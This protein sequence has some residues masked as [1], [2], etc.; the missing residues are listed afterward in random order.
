MHENVSGWMIAGVACLVLTGFGVAPVAM[1]GV[2]PQVKKPVAD[3]TGKPVPQSTIDDNS[4]EHSR[5]FEEWIAEMME[6]RPYPKSSIV[7]LDKNYARPHKASRWK[8]RIVRETADTVWLQPLPPEDPGSILH[9]FWLQEQ[10]RQALILHNL[11]HPEKVNMLNFDEPRAPLPFQDAL[12]FR[13]SQDGLPRSGQWRNNFVL[14]DLNEDGHA[15]MLM[16]PPR[17]GQFR[18]PVILLGDGHGKFRQW[19]TV[20]WPG[21]V[22]FDYGGV[23]VA[24][25]D[26]DGHQDVV[27]AIHFKDQYVLFGDGKGGFTRFQ[28]LPTPK[29]EVHSQAVTVADFNGDG[30]QDLAFLAEVSYDIKTAESLTVPSVWVLENQKGKGWKVH[31]KGLPTKVMGMKLSATD[32]NGDGN[33]DLLLSSNAQDWRNL[34]FFNQFDKKTGAW[35]WATNRVGGVLAGAFHYSVVPEMGSGDQVLA[36]FQQF[37]LMPRSEVND[38]GQRSRSRSGLVRYTV[39]PNGEMDSKVLELDEK[40]QRSNPW[41]RLASG[42]I[43]GDGRGD[44]VLLR[45]DGTMQVLLG[46]DNGGFVVEETPE[47]KP[48]GR[49]YDVQIRDLDGDGSGEIILMTAN[50]KKLPGGMAIL[51]VTKSSGSQVPK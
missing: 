39:H 48:I 9:A 38:N 17:E 36:V 8:F 41:W 33:P 22:P 32:L 51:H 47:F 50:T 1:A 45:H 26:H 40:E 13:I 27:V 37:Q 28:K 3:S 20:H 49:P 43:N 25:F 15:D 31:L 10:Q 6:P 12:H 21:K 4:P 44:V 2:T 7:R 35:K 14:A 34:V 24:D 29:E 23:A 42:D 30:W 11:E 46:D 19:K 18:A 5:S 16:P